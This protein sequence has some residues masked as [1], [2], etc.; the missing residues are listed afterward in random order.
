MLGDANSTLSLRAES[1]VRFTSFRSNVTPSRA[2]VFPMKTQLLLETIHPYRSVRRWIIG[3]LIALS[4][5]I[6]LLIVH[7]QDAAPLAGPDAPAQVANG[8]TATIIQLAIAHPIIGSLLLVLGTLRL[9]LKPIMTVIRLVVAST[10]S[11]T[12]DQ[13]L[14]EV[15]HSWAYTLFLFSLDWL[16]SIKLP[17]KSPSPAVNKSLSALAVA[18]LAAALLFAG[19]ACAPLAPGGVYQG[20]QVLHKAELITTTSYDVIHTYVTWEQENRAALARFPEIK[21]SADVMRRNA[22]QWFSTANALHDAYVANPTPENRDALNTALAVL[23]SALSEAVKYM[24]TAA[25]TP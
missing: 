18:G 5:F 21:Q 3:V 17:A 14:D 12:D 24:S 15:E 19:T 25:A 11:K 13:V 4:L 6:G 20:D 16:A 2:G 7:A 9:C 8:I 23:Q 1:P 10:P 22:K